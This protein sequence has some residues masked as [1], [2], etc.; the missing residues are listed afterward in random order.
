MGRR[1]SE[2]EI[3]SQK[4]PFPRSDGYGIKAA[5]THADLVAMFDHDTSHS[6]RLKLLDINRRILMQGAKLTEYTNG[7]TSKPY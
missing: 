6:M 2:D 4:R 5:V 1:R 7:R 3:K